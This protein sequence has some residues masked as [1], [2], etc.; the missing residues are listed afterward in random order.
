MFILASFSAFGVFL[1]LAAI[2]FLVLVVSFVAGEI[3]DFG[4]W[5]GDHDVDTHGGGPSFLSGRILSVFV[6]AFGGFGAIGIHSGFG[7]GVSTAMGLASG[8]VF[9]GIVYVFVRFL[10]GQE[11]SSEVHVSDLIGGTASV[12]VTIP[13]GG[14]GQVRC[15]LGESVVEKIARSVDGEEIASNALVKIEAVVGDTMI[16]RKS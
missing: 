2:G 11:A 7:I 14:L 15:Q 8:F 13:K 12:S 4:D 5:F 9:G 6:T 10:H 1:G 16:V 3:F